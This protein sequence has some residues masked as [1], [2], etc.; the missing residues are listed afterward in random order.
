MIE[1]S[2]L[3]LVVLIVFVFILGALT[4]EYI[5]SQIK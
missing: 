4:W 5:Q 3:S 1:I 2:N